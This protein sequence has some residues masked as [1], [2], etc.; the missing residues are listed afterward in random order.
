MGGFASLKTVINCF[1]LATP[2]IIDV[3][4]KNVTGNARNGNDVTLQVLAEE[5]GAAVVDDTR[6]A[7]LVVVEGRQHV[8]R[9]VLRPFLAQD[10]LPSKV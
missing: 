7:F 8:G 6:H 3:V 2:G 4:S 9:A 5:I 1:Q 10:P